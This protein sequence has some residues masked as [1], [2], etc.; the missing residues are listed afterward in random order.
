MGCHFLILQLDFVLISR[1]FNESLKWTN[2]KQGQNETLVLSFDEQDDISCRVK[3]RL[4]LH[5]DLCWSLR[6]SRLLQA[7]RWII[8]NKPILTLQQVLVGFFLSTK[9]LNRTTWFDAEANFLLFP[10]YSENY[11]VSWQS[12]R[13]L[14]H[15]NSL[16]FPSAPSLPNLFPS[17]SPHV[18]LH[19]PSPSPSPKYVSIYHH[20]HWN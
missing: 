12:A 1:S 5:L 11:A 2:S 16:I 20:T 7:H 13:A 4:T 18:P 19:L 10:T 14:L 8:R 3:R 15:D 6:N 9:G 17:T